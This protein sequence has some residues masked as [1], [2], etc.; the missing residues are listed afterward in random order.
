MILIVLMILPMLLIDCIADDTYNR[1]KDFLTYRNNIYN[2]E[3]DYPQGVKLR[4]DTV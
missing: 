4:V 3:F 2:F 1:P